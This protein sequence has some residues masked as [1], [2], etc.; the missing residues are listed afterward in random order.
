MKNHSCLHR[1][2]NQYHTA[3]ENITNY[4][5]I[6]YRFHSLLYYPDNK[7]EPWA[8]LYPFHREDKIV[9]PQKFT[10]IVRAKARI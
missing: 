2:L 10:Q 3:E 8:F 4:K 6:C 1:N 5:L 9:R 7:I